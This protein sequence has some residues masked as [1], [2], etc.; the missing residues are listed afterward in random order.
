[1]VTDIQLPTDSL[2][3]QR[4]LVILIYELFSPWGEIEDIH[5]NNHK[6]IAFIKYRHRYYAEFAREAMM[7]QVLQE[8]STDPITIKWALDNPFDKSEAMRAQ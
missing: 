6:C 4:D 2:T 1:M 8:G 3:P 7:E 5:F